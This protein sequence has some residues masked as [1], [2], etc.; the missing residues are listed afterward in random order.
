LDGK[1]ITDDKEETMESFQI[2]V[3]NEVGLHARPAAMFVKKAYQ[4]Q[5]DILIRNLTTDSDWVNAKSILE[6][7][8]LGVE[9]DHDIEVTTEGPDEAQAAKDLEKLIRGDF[10]EDA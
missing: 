1:S 5:S 9:Q 6:V 3:I 8:T 2:T 7:L 10:S 4:F